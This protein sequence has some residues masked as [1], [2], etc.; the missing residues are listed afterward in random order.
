MSSTTLQHPRQPAHRHAPAFT[1]VELLVVISIVAMLVALLLPALSKAQSASLS[2][3]CKANQRQMMTAML[4]YV[5]DNR[6]YFPEYSKYFATPPVPGPAGGVYVLW[7]SR[8]FVGPY[9]SNNTIGSSAYANGLNCDNPVITCPATIYPIKIQQPSGPGLTGIGYNNIS[10]NRIV[11]SKLGPTPLS[12]FI[13]PTRTVIFIDTL[14]NSGWNSWTIAETTLDAPSYER[15][16][17]T[18]N[19]AFADG[20]V[21]GIRYQSASSTLVNHRAR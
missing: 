8:L 10:D 5:V 3:R 20:H 2:T 7:Y 21:N 12:R 14:K 9:L 11:H 18:A 17:D 15:H 13:T 16:D 6:D 4:N 1:L 19:A